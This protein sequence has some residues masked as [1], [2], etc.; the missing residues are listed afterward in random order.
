MPTDAELNAAFA[1]VFAKLQMPQPIVTGQA[2][3][4][5]RV[6]GHSWAEVGALCAVDGPTASGRSQQW[7][8]RSARHVFGCGFKSDSDRVQQQQETLQHLDAMRPHIRDCLLGKQLTYHASLSAVLTCCTFTGE[9]PACTQCHSSWLQMVA[10]D[11]ALSHYILA[12]YYLN[13]GKF[14]WWRL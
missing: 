6:Q 11:Y 1:P 3:T 8:R 10:E 5:L 2:E 13:A 12:Y 14:V 7:K 9:A 4:H